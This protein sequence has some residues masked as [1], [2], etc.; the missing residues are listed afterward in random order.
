MEKQ[1]SL[2]KHSLKKQVLK[3]P[4]HKVFW[5]PKAGKKLGLQR[6]LSLSTAA[7]ADELVDLQALTALLLATH[8]SS[9]W[10]MT[11]SSGFYRYLQACA[12][13]CTYTHTKNNF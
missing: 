8:D 1:L 3:S 4:G 2:K 9:L 10:G 12:H 5:L 6:W 7:P 11:L 13:T